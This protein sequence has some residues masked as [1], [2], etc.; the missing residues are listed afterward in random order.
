MSA[1]AARN[2]RQDFGIENRK[3]P[4]FFS[5][6]EDLGPGVPQAHVLRKAFE[7]LDLDGILCTENSPLIYFKQ[8]NNVTPDKV[9]DLHKQFWNH[10]GAPILVLITGT[11]I[12]I[13]SGMS[14]PIPAH[15]GQEKPPSLVETLDRV[16]GGLREFLTA[17]ESGEFF[18][19]YAKSFNPNHR[20][21]RALLDNLRNTRAKLDEIT[22]SNIAP[23]VLDALLCR[24][25][26]ACYLFDR[27]VINGSYLQKA[28]V[29]DASHLRDV[30]AIQPTGNA[31]AALYDLFRE[32]G[33]DFNGDL[34][35]DNLDAEARKVTNRHIQVLSD[36]FHGTEVRGGQQSFWPYDFSAIPIETISAIYEHFLKAADHQ[37]GAFYTPRFLAE[38]VLDIALENFGSL[39]GKKFFDPACGSGIFLVGLFIRMAE[40]WRQANPKARNERSRRELRDLLTSSLFGVDINPTACRITAFSLYLAYLDQLAPRDIQEL[41]D[42][43]GALPRLVYDS[44]GEENAGRNIFCTD[45]F[46]DNAAIPSDVDLVIGNP[47]WGS[48]AKENT[49]AGKWCKAKNKAIPDKQIAAAFSWKAA[50]HIQ[51]KDVFVLYC[52]M[53][54]CLIT[55]KRQSNIKG[56]GSART[57]LSGFLIYP[58][59]DGFFL[60]ERFIRRSSSVIKTKNLLQIIK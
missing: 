34:F 2:W 56:S 26:F 31:K 19:Q 14:R 18:R 33:K 4:S 49:P 24:M 58:T 57:K 37:A 17:A 45:F 42:K 28:G 52:R 15:E 39:Q 12:H 13:Y 25:V 53:D 40:E 6:V 30:L 32:L 35:S 22:Q 1:D 44:E 29:N 5:S 38:V 11:Q 51:I 16:S 55:V 3:P 48:I 60:T 54:C 23:R 8:M 27:K 46:V 59:S 50:E 36:F 47:P 7:L 10:G 21:D 43:G 41:Q 20:I 9:L